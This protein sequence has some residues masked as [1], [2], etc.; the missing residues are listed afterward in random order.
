MKKEL[1]IREI[2]LE[3]LEILKHVIE[4]INNNNLNYSILSGTLL[5]AIRHKGFIPWDDDIDIGLPRPDYE[6]FIK[7]YDKCNKNS[8]MELCCYEKNNLFQPFA[9][10]V[11]REIEIKDHS[12]CDQEERF[13]W[14]DIFPIDG[15][16]ADIREV[17]RLYKK[18]R[19][20]GKLLYISHYKVLKDK[21]SNLPKKIL[22]LIVKPYASLYSAESI[23]KIAKKYDYNESEYVGG[24]V[25][26]YGPQERNRKVDVDNYIDCYFEGEKVKCF[27]GYDI[28]LSNLY[29]NY[30]ELPPENKRVTHGIHAFKRS[31]G[32]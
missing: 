9:K 21:Y 23:I 17:R 26:P 12:V 29:H 32:D 30:M 3:E 25:W 11:N 16:P 14:I 7:I 18:V 28:Y 10:V 13:L 20:I 22:K 1:T 4:I 24:V 15:L 19:R 27:R 31:N 2:Q 6:K 8:N 5:G